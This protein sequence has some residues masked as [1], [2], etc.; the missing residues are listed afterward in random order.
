[1]APPQGYSLIGYGSMIE[2]HPRM[3]AYVVA[4]RQAVRPGSVVLD[5]GA[6]TGIFSLLSVQFGA[7]HVHAVEPNDAVRV[8]RDF[9]EAN[10]CADRITF[11]QTLSTEISLPAPADVI[12]SDLRGVLPLLQHHIPSII[13]A[14][15]RH[16]ADGGHLIPQCDTIWA[17]LVDSPESYQQYERPWMVNDLGLEMRAGHPLVV[18]TWCRVTLTAERLLVPPQRW[19]TLD[20]RTVDSPHIDAKMIWTAERSGTAHGVLVWFDTQLLDGIGFSNAPDK[21]KLIYGQA[22]FP[23][24]QPVHLAVG[25]QVVVRL[26]ANLVAGEY[27]WRWETEVFSVPASSSARRSPPERRLRLLQSTFL[28][29]A[30]GLEKLHRCEAGYV[31][32]LSTSGQIDRYLLSLIDGQL[33]LGEI[34]RQAAEEFPHQFPR[35]QDALTR[36]AELADKFGK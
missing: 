8:A 24:Q 9:A 7:G 36:A 18:N 1:M 2:D 34:A 10:G 3:N 21:P 5:I 11:H 31:P 12:I 26:A 35:W 14:R 27:V 32:R 16:L 15:Q 4:L 25:E 28:G 6:G 29:G 22:F 13:D 19:T 23:L 30:L 33:S 20:Y 17:A